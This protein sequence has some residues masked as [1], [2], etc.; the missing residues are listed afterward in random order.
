MNTDRPLAGRTALITGG[1]RGIGAAIARELANQGACVAITYNT[2]GQ[3]AERLVEELGT[4]VPAVALRADSADPAA[5][6]ACVQEVAARFGE[7]HILVNNAGIGGFGGFDG[8]DTVGLARRLL[9]VHVLGAVAAIQAVLP[10]MPSGGRIISIGSAMAQR[11]PAAGLSLYAMSKSA[12]T[13]MTRGLSRDLG[14]RGITVNL[15]E[16][17]PTDT[18]MNPQ[19][20]PHAAG[21][22]GLTALGRYAAAGEIAAAVAFLASPAA[23][24]VTGISLTV[25]GGFTA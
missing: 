12:L 11:A 8:Q 16:P 1:A 9:D 17:G 18:E 21:T 10:H 4:L 5:V 20:G 23:S 2:S 3:R 6:E 13:G 22:A 25:D 15:V 14:S 7:V 24:Y 19:N